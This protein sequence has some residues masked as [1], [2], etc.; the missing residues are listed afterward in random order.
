MHKEVEAG[1]ESRGHDQRMMKI[2]IGQQSTKPNGHLQWS[3]SRACAN[4]G[5]HK[6][7][8]SRESST[9]TRALD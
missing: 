4:Q 3:R 2:W 8:D 6:T 1:R 7:Q 5:Q 9:G